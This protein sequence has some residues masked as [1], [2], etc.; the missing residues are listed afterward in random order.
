MPRPPSR[1]KKN[2]IRHFSSSVEA[3]DHLGS[4]V[5][6][7][8][9]SNH[10]LEHT[11]NPLQEIKNLRRLLK[12]GGTIHFVIPCDSINYEYDPKDI[13]YHLFSWSP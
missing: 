6:D 4:G 7:V 11:L 8:I 10:A 13:N 2:G 3:L 9:I 12:T 5:A 1:L